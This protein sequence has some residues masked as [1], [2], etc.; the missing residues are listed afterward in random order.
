M[1][2]MTS[3]L[4]EE[5]EAMADIGRVLDTIADPDVRQRVLKWVTERFGSGAESA[6]SAPAHRVV[7]DD[8]A[9]AVDSL[10]DMFRE[11]ADGDDLDLVPEQRRPPPLET[12]VRSFVADFERLAADW[13]GV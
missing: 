5:L 9:L 10:D 4:T 8:A 11:L 2:S 7:I 12:A 13:H 1:E 3:L 6:V